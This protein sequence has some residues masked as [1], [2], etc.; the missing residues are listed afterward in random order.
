MKVPRQSARRGETRLLVVGAVLVLVAAV[1]IGVSSR[2]GGSG[3]VD[4]TSWLQSRV[5]EDRWDFLTSTST[6]VFQ[7]DEGGFD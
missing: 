6:S 3:E 5:N 7:G 4:W 1:A 2:G